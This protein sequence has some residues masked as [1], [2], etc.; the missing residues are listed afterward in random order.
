MQHPNSKDSQITLPV[1]LEYY[2]NVSCSIDNDKYFEAIMVNAQTNKKG[3][4][5]FRLPS[6][7][8]GER[9]LKKIC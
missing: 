7:L 9:A 4:T 6:C 5:Y 2:I 1:R 3:L 8:L